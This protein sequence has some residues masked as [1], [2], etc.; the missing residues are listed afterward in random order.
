MDIKAAV[1]FYFSLISV[2]MISGKKVE[3]RN[4]KYRMDY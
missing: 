4:I 1:D 3:F 2:E